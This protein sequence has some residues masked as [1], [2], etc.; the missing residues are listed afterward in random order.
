MRQGH[1]SNQDSTV[2]VELTNLRK[3]VNSKQVGDAGEFE[4]AKQLCRVGV[5]ATITKAGSTGVDLFAELK[6]A[7]RHRAG[8]DAKDCRCWDP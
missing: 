6:G 8:Q 4:V 2:A 5:N 3:V 1:P 7:Q